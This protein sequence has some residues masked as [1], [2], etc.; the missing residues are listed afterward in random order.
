MML[1][2][3][4]REALEET[5]GLLR[6][7]G[8]LLVD[9]LS[10]SI[11]ALERADAA[12]AARVISGADQT[13]DLGRRIEASCIELMW[14][15]QPVAGD[16]RLVTAMYAIS[17]DLQRVNHY[18]VDVSKHGVRLEG[19]PPLRIWGPVRAVAD[20]TQ[21]IFQRAVDGY[22]LRNR[23]LAQSVLDDD[24]RYDDLCGEA[25]RKLQTVV[26]DDVELISP[27]TELLFVLTSLQRIGEPSISVAWHTAELL[28]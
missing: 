15:Q 9:A 27:A 14:K 8:V 10:H 3:A 4:Y 26:V 7:L 23:D 6:R 21:A 1:R 18:I 22:R 12:L 28:D 5:D 2:V 13:G 17:S 19:R 24:D 25:L 20:E 11:K 16:L